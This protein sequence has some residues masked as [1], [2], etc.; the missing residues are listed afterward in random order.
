MKKTVA[1]NIIIVSFL[2]LITLAY[3]SPNYEVNVCLHPEDYRSSTL[4]R[5]S[6]LKVRWVRMD[7]QYNESDVAMSALKAHN[8]KILAIIDNRTVNAADL[9]PELW[10]N[11]LY[12][13]LDNPIAQEIDAWEIWNEPNGAAYIPPENYTEMLKSAY[14]IIKNETG[15]L[16]ISGAL[17]PIENWMDYFN[18]V[19]NNTEIRFYY[20][21]L[22]VHLYDE[23]SANVATIDTLKGITNKNVWVTEI[24]RPSATEGYTETGQAEYLVD[25]IVGLTPEV[26]KIFI[27]EMYDN[28]GLVPEKEN[29]FGLL[30]IDDEE[31]EVYMSLLELLGISP[32]PTPTES[33]QSDLWYNNPYVFAV[34]IG[35]LVFAVFIAIE[36]Y[37]H[38]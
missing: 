18:A 25:N 12:D 4:D 13:I 15:A 2:V 16:V 11:T 30:T 27:Y 8:I 6:E 5:L 14:Q 29:Y 35:V 9:T 7:Y 34:T 26:D 31:K 36:I 38:S 10:N 1:T 3:A 24:G 28:T 20:D 22:G 21:Y 33:S 19:Y 37:K 23:L 17:A 32:D